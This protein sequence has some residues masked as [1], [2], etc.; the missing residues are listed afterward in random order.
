MLSVLFPHVVNSQIPVMPCVL[1]VNHK[2]RQHVVKGMPCVSI[3]VMI[4]ESGLKEFFTPA[5]VH[6]LLDREE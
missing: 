2:H 4:F 1:R 5:F 3:E 6:K